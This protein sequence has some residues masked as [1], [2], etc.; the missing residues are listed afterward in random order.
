MGNGNGNGS[1]NAIANECL[2]NAA[3]VGVDGCR[4]GWF[5][6]AHS[7]GGY[8]WGVARRFDQIMCDIQIPC[9]VM[10]D[11]PIGLAGPSCPVRPCDMLARRRLGRRSASVFSTPSRTALGGRDYADA[12]QRNHQ[13]TGRKLSRQCWNLFPRIREVD[14]WLSAHRQTKRM[15]FESHPELCFAALAGGQP[16]THYKKTETGFSERLALLSAHWPAAPA[17]VEE[18]LA[19]LPRSIAARD[20]MLDALVLAITASCDEHEL[21]SIPANPGRDQTGLPMSMTFPRV[22][23]A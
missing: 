20:D 10:V 14:A 3:A 16:M 4:G 23:N 5:F 1:G 9:R 18:A 19:N 15:V 7:D 6:F 11:I 17:A 12:S 22:L 21:E 8:C 13:V 2:R